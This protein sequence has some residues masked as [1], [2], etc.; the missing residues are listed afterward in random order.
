MLQTTVPENVT[1]IPE[2]SEAITQPPGDDEPLF[3]RI[4]VHGKMQKYIKFAL[5]FLEV[6]KLFRLAIPIHQE[7][8]VLVT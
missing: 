8:I 7:R 1:D 2:N 5:Q 4:A 3:M 6:G